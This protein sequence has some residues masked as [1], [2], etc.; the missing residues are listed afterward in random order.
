MNS[1]TLWKFLTSLRLTVFC[2]SVG[3]V[4]VFLGTIAQVDEGL[5][6]VQARWFKGWAV[7]WGPHGSALKVPVFP[8]GYLIGTLLLL[9][10]FA[11]H[12]NRFTW[13]WK[14]VGIHLTHF[15]VILLLAGQLATDML[16]QESLISLREGQ[17]QNYSED[18]KDTELI[19][20]ADAGNG[21]DRVISFSQPLI[22]RSQE[23][24]HDDLPFVVRIKHFYIN[25][26]ILTR[27][28]V[29]EMGQRLATALATLEGEY[30]SPEA[31]V[32]QAERSL[33]TEG[34][35]QVWRE[36]LKAI[37]EK[38]TNDIVAAAKRIAPQNDQALKLCAELKKRFREQMLDKFK[39]M[40]PMMPMAP[41]M[42]Y[43]AQRVEKGEVI[44]EESVPRATNAG[45]GKDLVLEP[46][47]EVKSMDDRNLP[48][49]IVEVVNQGQS[50]GD[51]VLSP[52]LDSQEFAIGDKAYRVA[53][54]FERYY[55]P[56]SITLLK[57]THDIYRGTDIPKNF[58]S[59]V[60]VDNDQTGE[61][62][63]VDIYM[64]NP[65][66]YAG[67][68]FYQY[69]MSPAEV[70]ASQQRSTLQVVRNPSWLTPYFGCGLVA[71]G[72]IYQFLF[73][74][75]A[76]VAKRRTPAPVPEKPKKKAGRAPEH[77][78]ASAKQ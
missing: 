21:Q 71:L 55:H 9:N 25:A 65:L 30:S 23:L 74:L 66:R 72:M 69:Q 38:D 35:T 12:I 10:L 34:R 45:A 73:H 57:M 47:A 26:E 3:I 8:G 40:G 33:E 36:A 67:L 37:G 46:L 4:L 1:R 41:S 53:L 15:G 75:V 43:A 18:H 20:S 68:T 16:S 61:H 28:N 2:L 48:A 22:A 14:K 70:D 50:L 76:F 63:E 77:A 29:I 5:Y 60:R 54:R 52:L 39:N 58:Q 19:L 11:S 59:R 78:V 49:A 56:F 24:R 51:I 27:K 31:L 32:A 7:W 6:E 64:N 17:T 13:G 42:R 62:R 44:T